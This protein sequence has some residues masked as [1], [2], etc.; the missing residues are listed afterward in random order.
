MNNTTT[1]T[2]LA[3]LKVNLDH[4]YRDY[5][6][7]LEP[8]VGATLRR[9]H[10]ESPGREV[11]T[12]NVKD[13]LRD[14]FGLHLPHF[15]IESV[16][17]RLTRKGLLRRENHRVF[18]QGELPGEDLEAQRHTFAER[19]TRLVVALRAF[20]A[21]QY[22]IIWSDEQSADALLIYLGAFS[23]DCLRTYEQKSALPPV[24]AP[25]SP[26]GA[27]G[28]EMT[29]FLVNALARHAQEHDS[30]LF[31][32]L[33]ELVKGHMLAN[34]L[35]CDDLQTFDQR[36]NGVTFFLDTPL[37]L[38][39]MGMDEA[40]FEAPARELIELVKSVAGR[41]CVFDHTLEEADNVLAYHE[42]WLKRPRGGNRITDSLR[43][44]TKTPSDLADLRGQVERK[45]NELG[46]TVQSAPAY[47]PERYR[48]EIGQAELSS[49]LQD[50]ISYQNS[51]AADFDTLSMRAIYVLRGDLQP[52]DLEHCRAVLVS[53]N[54]SLAHFAYHYGRNMTPPVRTS[55]VITDF[56]L[57]NVAWLKAPMAR[58]ELPRME[59][60]ALCYAA[61]KPPEALWAKY[62]AEID[63]LLDQG[64]IDEAQH[65]FL[66]SKDAQHELADLTLGSDDAYSPLL[67]HEV[68]ERVRA[69]AVREVEQ[70]EQEKAIFRQQ[71]HEKMLQERDNQI[72]AMNAR[73]EET[74]V[75]LSKT[76]GLV[77]E[78]RA[79]RE[80][81]RAERDSRLNFRAQKM[82]KFASW[83]FFSCIA[84]I[85]TAVAVVATLASQSPKVQLLNVNV[86][87]PYIVTC[88]WVLASFGLIGT[89]CGASLLH[90]KNH[91]E[92][93]W[94]PKFRAFLE[95]L[96]I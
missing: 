65:L 43:M 17:K 94:T 26:G 10:R 91:L 39:L 22:Q 3:M 30:E 89:L 59:I 18:V 40:A 13:G 71:E 74:N 11:T 87:K 76:I 14:G 90:W 2:S 5:A 7:Y 56:S 6:G 77:E 80:R 50:E 83:T 34:A 54:D 81:E 92:Q 15:V 93:R 21:E 79:Q 20:A 25:P 64:Q 16:L 49:A 68:V 47:R 85:I 61:L 88:I 1:L 48:L 70:R 44:A 36:F 82:A 4:N 35:V 46:V 67:A 8:F 31:E 57:A 45:L 33:V 23:I 95:R 55:L 37:V 24:S 84:A 66:R 58:P 29:I 12:A 96:S 60:L 62:V 32:I 51:R 52:R 78:G 42:N 9:F 73:L 63:K 19:Q 69:K 41:V 86:P 75:S 27:N 72:Q 28:Q 53:N 38:R